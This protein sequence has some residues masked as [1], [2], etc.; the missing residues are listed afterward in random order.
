MSQWKVNVEAKL[1]RLL[2]MPMVDP[3]LTDLF[4]TFF[5]IGLTAFG[6]LAITA[7]VRKHIVE[8]RRWLSASTFDSGLALCQLIPG[9]IVMQLAAYI[10]LKIR[11]LR[12]AVV[13]FVGFGLPAF[14]IMII[15]SVIYKHSKN[16][17]GVEVILGG[18]RVVIVAIVANAA[19]IFGKKN[20]HQINDWAIAGVAATLFLTKLHPALVLIV[21]ALLG[22]LLTKKE[23]EIPMKI[24]GI[25]TG[26]FF[27]W[28]L[29]AVVTSA[30]IL[31]FVN[32][33]Y[34]TLA[35]IMLRIDLFSFGGGL[36]A[37]PIMYNEL[38]D[39][40]GW[41]SEQ[42]FM[43]GVI[44]G[45]VTPGSIIISATFFGYM[46]FGFWGGILATVCVFTPSFL[47]LMGIIPFFDKLRSYPQFNKVING[48]LCSFVGL[49]AIVTYRFALGIH[50][51]IGNILF[52]LVAFVLLMRKV[53]V[54]WIVLGGVVMALV[55]SWI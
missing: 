54:I 55:M 52:T 3:S 4:R 36:A 15:L 21:A 18:L 48:I 43:D 1:K 34:F 45:Q 6:G 53:D 19:Y 13:C 31:F 12:G 50:W 39:L 40:F 17:E 47:I 38:V 37:M 30:T 29:L 22:L 51:N 41:F 44:L 25:K 16:I 5:W 33:E 11:G 10:G 2:S 35:T 23:L 32:K 7:H 28:L 42:V 9:A 20:F 27:L 8:K 46:H 49:L 24:V 14:L 26:R